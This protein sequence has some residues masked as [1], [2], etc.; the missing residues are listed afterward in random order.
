MSGYELMREVCELP[1]SYEARHAG[2]HEPGAAREDYLCM[3]QHNLQDQQRVVTHLSRR[4]SRLSSIE[5]KS[6]QV[7]SGQSIR[8]MKDDDESRKQF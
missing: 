1:T 8:D 4:L 2:V 3:M 6:G 7:K 5:V